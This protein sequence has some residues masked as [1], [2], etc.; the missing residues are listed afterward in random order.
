[1]PCRRPLMRRHQHELVATNNTAM[2]KRRHHPV[3]IY[4]ESPKVIHAHPGEFRSVVQRLTGAAPSRTAIPAAATAR[5]QFP[6]QLYEALMDKVDCR[7]AS[8]FAV[9][10]LPCSYLPRGGAITGA[11]FFGT[12][13]SQQLLSSAFLCEDEDHNMVGSVQPC[14]GTTS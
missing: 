14:L 3:I 8:P 6:F 1:M 13:S 4:V 9:G 2:K 5:P 7:D 12:T 11:N 10:T